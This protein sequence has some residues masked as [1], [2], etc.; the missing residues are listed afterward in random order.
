MYLNIPKTLQKISAILIQK[1]C[2]LV[3]EISSILLIIYK[4]HISPTNIL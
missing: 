1:D 4:N 2:L 3:I